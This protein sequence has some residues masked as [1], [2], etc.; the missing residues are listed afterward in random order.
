MKAWFNGG[1]GVITKAANGNDIII[2]FFVHFCSFDDVI[3]IKRCINVWSRTYAGNVR[4]KR[5]VKSTQAH[6]KDL[7]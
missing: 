2:C 1:N 4:V 3:S 7:Q 5:S 6:P